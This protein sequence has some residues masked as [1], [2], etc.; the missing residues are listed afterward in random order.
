MEKIRRYSLAGLVYLLNL[1]DLGFTLFA[2][3]LGAEELNPLM[4]DPQVQLIYKTVLVGAALLWLAGRRERAAELG[5]KLCAVL[6][7]AV[8]A[9]HIALLLFFFGL[10]LPQTLFHL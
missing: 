1:M 7:A 2:L 5:L 10:Q 4:R 8:V 9:Y 3:S 6:Y